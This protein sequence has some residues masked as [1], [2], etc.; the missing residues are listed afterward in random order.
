MPSKGIAT[1]CRYS[2]PATT[3]R[4][5]HVDSVQ[6]VDCTT[7]VHFFCR[8]VYTAR[9]VDKSCTT[10]TTERTAVLLSCIQ[11]S[12]H[13]IIVSPQ[14]G[15]FAH[16]PNPFASLHNFHQKCRKRGGYAIVIWRQEHPQG[17]GIRVSDRMHLSR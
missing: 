1:Y 11:H 7:A 4:S 13:T 5:T 12:L 3:L 15:A 8:E 2:M 6:Q 17:Y 14:R 10:R 9:F 16:L